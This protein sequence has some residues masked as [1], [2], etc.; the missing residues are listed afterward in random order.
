MQTQK[1]TLGTW[2]ED[3]ASL[4]YQRKGFKVIDRN[5]RTP[6]GEIDIVATKGRFIYFIEVKTRSTT[7]FGYPEEVIS[8]EKRQRMEQCAVYYCKEKRKRR[9][10]LHHVCSLRWDGEK[11]RLKIFEY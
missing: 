10:R 6:Q 3:V 8:A 7:T 1:Q 9:K 4:Y 11:V 5:Y 2:G